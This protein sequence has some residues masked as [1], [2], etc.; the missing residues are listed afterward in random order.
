MNLKAD[1]GAPAEEHPEP[2][3]GG[4]DEAWSAGALASLVDVRST[5]GAEL[6]RTLDAAIEQASTLE[7]V[8][9][10]AFDAIGELTLDASSYELRRRADTL[11][12]LMQQG[13][14]VLGELQAVAG[15]LKLMAAVRRLDEPS[16]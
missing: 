11:C 10:Q 13:A 2:P 12:G 1:T 14:S 4:E 15:R 3:L 16:T 7:N 9:L 5:L 8:S 6:R